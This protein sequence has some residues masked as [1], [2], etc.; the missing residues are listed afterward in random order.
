L[1]V[2]TKVIILIVV[3]ISLSLLY[4]VRPPGQ[5]ALHIPGIQ[6]MKRSSL[7]QSGNFPESHGPMIFIPYSS[8]MSAATLPSIVKL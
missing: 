4:F 3:I 5:K 7:N 1:E 6:Q 8:E 2:Q